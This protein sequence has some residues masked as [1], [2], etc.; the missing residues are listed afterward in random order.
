[1]SRKREAE[2][3]ARMQ[4]KIARAGLRVVKRELL[5]AARSAADRYEYS[6]QILLPED[7]RRRLWGAFGTIHE[8]AILASVQRT[9]RLLKSDAAWIEKKFDWPELAKRFAF[10]FAAS[11]MSMKVTLV[12]ASLLSS[13][14]RV[15]KQGMI[16][17]EG[18]DNIAARIKKMTPKLTKMQAAR[19][20]RTEVHGAS[21][22][23][24]MKTAEVIGDDIIL[25]REWIA[26]EDERTRSAHGSADE[27]RRGF[28][29]AFDVGGEALMYPGDPDGSAGNIINCRC[30]AVEVLKEIQA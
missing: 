1:M 11:H 26:V 10:E 22:Y 2:M 24:G 9:Q 19:I 27:Q 21:G 25:E 30:S 12:E 5:R 15:I 6:G 4:D 13:L 8:H 18:Q 17:G 14:T 16:E 28:G 23:A 20:A 7:L 3:I 29:E